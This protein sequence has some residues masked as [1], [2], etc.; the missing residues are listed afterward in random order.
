[1]AEKIQVEIWSDVMCPFC[2]IGKRQ[3][4]AALA[5]FPEKDRVEITWRSFQLD[6]SMTAQPGRSIDEYLAARKGFSVEQ[7]KQMHVRMTQN[8]AQY[9]LDYRFDKIVVNNSHAAHRL[10][11]AAK[12]ESRGDALEEAL[13]HAYFTEGRDIGDQAVLADLARQAG[14]TEEAAEDAW[15]DFDG[16]WGAKVDAE[17]AEAQEMGSTGV[18]FFVF[19]RQYGV[20]GAQGTPT[21]TKVLEKLAQE[22]PA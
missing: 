14:V 10:I 6:P 15:N 16:K 7:S 4:E 20:T 13:F 8:A 17:A 1:M 21:F 19:Q 18:P 9:G 3:F 5:D 22:F 12:A 11:Q 2:Y